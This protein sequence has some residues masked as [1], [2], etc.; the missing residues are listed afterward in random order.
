MGSNGGKKGREGGSYCPF[1]RPNLEEKRRKLKPSTS[2]AVEM[3]YLIITPKL[4][5]NVPV[6]YS[7]ST[8]MQFYVFLYFCGFMIG[9]P[10]IGAVHMTLA[11][12]FGFLQQE[13]V[14]SLPNFF[15]VK[16]SRK[17]RGKCLAYHTGIGILV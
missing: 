7:F 9:F 8:S 14:A 5:S 12:P 13:K 10:C 17:F 4:L 1:G 11:N 6:Q 15:S 16:K 3:A 2:E